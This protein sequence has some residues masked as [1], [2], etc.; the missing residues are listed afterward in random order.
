MTTPTYVPPDPSVVSGTGPYPFNAPYLAATD[1]SLVVVLDGVRTVLAAD[2]WSIA[3]EA[4][5]TGGNIT[6]TLTAA[7]AYADGLLYILRDTDLQQGWQGIAGTR[8]K[9]LETQLDRLTR[10]AQD[11]HG[12]MA[13][14]LRLDR[15]LDPLTPVPNTVLT[16]DADGNLVLDPSTYANL[17]AAKAAE[18]AAETA[19]AT[20]QRVFPTW[21]AALND[22]HL[23]VGQIVSIARGTLAQ[24]EEAEVVAAATYDLTGYT[25]ALIGA[26]AVSGV[27]LVSL[28]K[29]YGTATEMQQDRR[30]NDRFVTGETVLLQDRPM[31]VATS[32][33]TRYH[34]VT[35]GAVKLMDPANISRRISNPIHFGSAFPRLARKMGKF[36][37]GK[38]ATFT[39]IP[40]MGIG[41]SV[42]NGATLPTPTVDAPVYWFTA[43]LDA[44]VNKAGI[45]TFTVDQKSVG[46]SSIDAA[47]Q[48][49]TSPVIT[50]KG[51]FLDAIDAGSTPSA[52]FIAEGMNDFQTA[53]FN[54]GE[55]FP[56]AARHLR[57][58]IQKIK[59]YGADPIVATTPHPHTGRQNY[60]MPPSVGQSYPEVVAAPVADA[61]LTPSVANSVVMGDFSGLGISIPADVRFLRGNEM[62]RQVAFEEGIP[63]IDVERYWFEAVAT[64]GQDALFDVGQTVHPNTLGHHVS[65]HRAISEFC[66]S[67]QF[68]P[69]IPATLPEF[70]SGMSFGLDPLKLAF[71]QA[72]PKLEAPV[73]ITAQTAKAYEIVVRGTDQAIDLSVDPTS[74]ALDLW[75]WNDTRTAAF[76]RRQYQKCWLSK[77]TPTTQTFAFPA[78]REG[79]ARITARTSADGQV[80][81]QTIEFLW[82]TTGTVLAINTVTNWSTYGPGNIITLS[83]TGADLILS[84]VSATTGNL[85][86]Y[87]SGDWRA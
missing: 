78:S 80:G 49:S 2:T 28:R 35:A 13:N 23:T 63:C 27:Q 76:V 87:L 20:A 57:E 64:L 6:L 29:A 72:N 7:T 69:A 14:T 61:A 24:P 34:Y 18:A 17:L 22:P 44:A 55:T 45:Y 15:P 70:I 66:A 41:S 82:S 68:S 19:A 50:I 67:L 79:K 74:H 1:L 75:G 77:A 81:S 83:V 31:V 53:L 25:G 71:D 84:I 85:N 10:A 8:E 73:D 36:K 62:I 54:A 4:S 51:Y 30:G 12:R 46:G 47:N 42:G 40:I 38:A 32:T 5:E 16:F 48:A 52:V 59:V 56:G 58:L 3:P 65:Y 26:N 43:E 39:V 60:S 9:G 33:E 21:T 86:I 37:Y 11:Q